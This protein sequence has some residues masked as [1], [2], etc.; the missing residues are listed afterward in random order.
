MASERVQPEPT[1]S[2]WISLHRTDLVHEVSEPGRVSG[3]D[4]ARSHQRRVEN[5]RVEAAARAIRVE[6]LK[7]PTET[8]R[9]SGYGVLLVLQM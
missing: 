3:L 1:V 4:R 5:G 6:S 8:E 9:V 7:H 2:L